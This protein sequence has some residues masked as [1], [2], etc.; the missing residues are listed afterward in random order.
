MT[1]EVDRTQVRQLRSTARRRRRSR[2]HYPL[3][4]ISARGPPSNSSDRDRGAPA[5]RRRP[6]ENC[7]AEKLPSG[8]SKSEDSGTPLPKSEAST[9]ATEW[10][11]FGEKFLLVA[12][13]S[14]EVPRPVIT[15]G[16]PSPTHGY[17]A[18]R[19]EDPLVR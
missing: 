19:S 15:H 1:N 12:S 5:S 14:Q 13:C 16:R 7:V 6:G 17:V 2:K 10:I 18:K 9:T 11:H 8:C 3:P 4:G